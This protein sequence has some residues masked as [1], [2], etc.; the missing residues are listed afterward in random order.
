MV[1]ARP[2][3]TARPIAHSVFTRVLVDVDHTLDGLA[4]GWQARVLAG[5]FG[6][7]IAATDLGRGAPAPTSR[8]GRDGHGSREATVLAQVAMSGASCLA[9][10]AGSYLRVNGRTSAL[11]IARHC[12]CSVLIA[13]ERRATAWPQRIV[14]GVDGSQESVQAAELAAVLARAHGAE[15]VRVTALGGK[16][17]DVDRI[18][19]RVP[20]VVIDP[21]APVDALVA[22]G[23]DADL[24]VVASRGRHGVG[25]LGS[26][27]ERVAD[28]ATAPVLIVRAT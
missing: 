25:P 5:S 28:R 11:G 14:V 16:V 26:V 9:V 8:A 21:R 17:V 27:S 10:G 22:A 2:T 3:V 7:L 24:I 23:R 15:L 12:P 4:A 18:R 19:A 1:T 6:E 20:L 13:R